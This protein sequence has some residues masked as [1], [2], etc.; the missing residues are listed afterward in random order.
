M[1]EQFS[2]LMTVDQLQEALHVG[3]NTAYELVQSGEIKSV[4]IGRRIRIPKRFVIDYIL[5]TCYDG[6]AVDGCVCTTEVTV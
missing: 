6:S 4:R 3:R 5:R 2:D 1:F